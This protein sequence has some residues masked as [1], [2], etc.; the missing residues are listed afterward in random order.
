MPSSDLFARLAPKEPLPLIQAEAISPAVILFADIYNYEELIRPLLS[1][2][3][4]PALVQGFNQLISSMTAVIL[5]HQG[6]LLQT[7]GESYQALF[8]APTTFSD[9]AQE[10]EAFRQT[11]AQ[12]LR[13]TLE[14]M[15]ALKN[16]PSTGAGSLKLS[17]GIDWGEAYL[18]LR[19]DSLQSPAQEI[20]LVGETACMA[21]RLNELAR[22]NEVV[23]TNLADEA[24]RQFVQEVISAS[25]FRMFTQKTE[26]KGKKGKILRILEEGKEEPAGGPA[27]L[28]SQMFPFPRPQ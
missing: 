20:L 26:M 10:E 5:R 7:T 3:R 21:R 2:G 24:D 6:Y 8:G 19:G 11:I 16:F 25:G 18:L 15:E 22:D 1:W 23:I 17:A 12:A 4:L 14:M 27:D 28:W 9:P 13:A